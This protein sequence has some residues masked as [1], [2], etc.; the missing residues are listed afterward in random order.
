MLSA[1]PD[2]KSLA[3]TAGADEAIEK[4]FNITDL[5]EAVIRHTG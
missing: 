2:I 5:R 4:P 1:N 3:K